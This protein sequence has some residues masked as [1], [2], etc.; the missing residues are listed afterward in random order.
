MV[1]PADRVYGY[2]KYLFTLFIKFEVGDEVVKLM[3][4]QLMSPLPVH[5]DLFADGTDFQASFKRPKFVV[6]EPGYK[7]L[8]LRLVR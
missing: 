8:M 1:I 5:S 6:A 4:R 7:N 3:W 2:A